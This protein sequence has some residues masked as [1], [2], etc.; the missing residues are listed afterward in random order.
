MINEHRKD[1]RVRVAILD[2]GVDFTHPIIS[3]AR[4]NKSIASQCFPGSAGTLPSPNSLDTLGDAHGH[5]THG[6][7][8]LLQTA[9]NASLYIAR[10][11]DQEGKLKYDEIPKVLYFSS[12]S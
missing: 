6:A 7:S 4:K 5:G 10:V 8:V 2:T 1:K 3:A 9:P 11:T 12:Q